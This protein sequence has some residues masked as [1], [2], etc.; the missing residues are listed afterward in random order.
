LDTGKDYRKKHEE[1]NT[2]YFTPI[3]KET[4]IKL[5]K[6]FDHYA[7]NNFVSQEPIQLYDRVLKIIKTSGRIIWFDFIAICGR[8]RSQKDYLALVKN[9]D[10]F[11][12][13]HVPVIQAHQHDLIVSLIHL[14]DV[15]YDA[16]K[17]LII[18]ADA[19]IPDLYPEGKYHFAFQRTRSRLMEMQNPD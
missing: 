8:P 11:I 12:V 17:K 6:I 4:E 13:S 7:K 18:S 16:H 9:Y 19:A 15:L 1:K 14:V 10:V 5:Q 3:K 2:F